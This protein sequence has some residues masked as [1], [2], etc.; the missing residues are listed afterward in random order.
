MINAVKRR[1]VVVMFA[2]GFLGFGGAALAP[3]ANAVGAGV[4]RTDQYGH[5]GSP[6][7]TFGNVGPAASC[8]YTGNGTVKYGVMVCYR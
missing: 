4:Y 2:L 1:A 8:A 5:Q 6:V 7:F 3:T